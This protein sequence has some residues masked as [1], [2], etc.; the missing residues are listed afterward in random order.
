MKELYSALM[1]AQQEF[2]PI[3][4]N[5]TAKAGSFSYSYAD[6][7]HVVKGVTPVL[8][9]NGLLLVQSGG[10]DGGLQGL[11]TELVHAETGQAID[12]FFALPKSEDAQDIGG[13]IT[14]FR[15]YAI[16]ALLGIVTED[17]NDAPK[18]SFSQ[19][20]ALPKGQDALKP[21]FE[22]DIPH[23]FPPGE[24]EG[25]HG[26]VIPLGKFKDREITSVKRQE[27]VDYAKYIRQQSAEKGET[28]KGKMAEF[29][30]KIDQL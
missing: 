25:A 30:S 28:P 10:T 2:P 5:K 20:P 13:S 22:D 18:K 1:K 15:R 9:R 27:L 21:P 14:F 24:R 29:L 11:A 16:C 17:D 8:H 4:K 26:Y 7:E 3:T 19:L 23:F 6:L 12:S